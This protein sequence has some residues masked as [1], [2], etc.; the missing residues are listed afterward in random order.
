MLPP[1]GVSALVGAGLLAIVGFTFLLGCVGAFFAA[2]FAIIPADHVSVALVLDAYLF[3]GLLTV[4]LVV[5]L[6]KRPVRVYF[7][8]SR[9]ATRAKAA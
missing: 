9:P 2:A 4:V 5:L 8:I 7:G 1:P 3:N 6:L